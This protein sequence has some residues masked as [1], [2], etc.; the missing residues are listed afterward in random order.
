MAAPSLIQ[1]LEGTFSKGVDLHLRGNKL[2][3]RGPEV[4]LGAGT[5]ETLRQL[6][7]R[8]LSTFD[9]EG[10]GKLFPLTQGQKAQWFLHLMAPEDTSYNVSIAFRV[11]RRL[12]RSAVKEALNAVMEKH[13]L[14]RSI[15]RSIMG[16]PMQLARERCSS[17]MEA[18]G[19]S[20][21]ESSMREILIQKHC[22]PF[23]LDKGPLARVALRGPAPRAAWAGVLG[24]LG[25]IL[26]GLIGYVLVERLF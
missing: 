17:M 20:V 1:E 26:A 22:F 11:S 23:N 13:D 15:I 19:E 5:L 21:S 25:T 8:I 12:S 3:L 24:G 14:L 6:K 16:E 2:E 10:S 4:T 7:P 9:G 18:E